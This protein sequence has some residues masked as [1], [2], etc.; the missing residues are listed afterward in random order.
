[1]FPL[2]SNVLISTFSLKYVLSITFNA[3]SINLFNKIMFALSASI[4]VDISENVD[5]Q[6]ISFELSQYEWY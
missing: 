3:E 2:A 6:S 4:V 1:M 5:I